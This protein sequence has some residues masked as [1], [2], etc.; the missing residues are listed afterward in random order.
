MKTFLETKGL[1]SPEL[2]DADWLEKLHFMVDM[3]SHLNMLNTS[4]QGKERTA[5]QMLEY[6]LA[7]EHKMTVFACTVYSV[8][9]D[10]LS[11]FPS[12]KKFKEEHNHINCEYLYHAISE[13]QNAFGERFRTFRQ[14]NAHYLSLS[15]HWTLAYPY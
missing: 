6:V 5:V 10:T 8:Q 15:L 13:M 4:L 12:L 14:E 3:T 11:H 1:T 7:F 2:E 9:T